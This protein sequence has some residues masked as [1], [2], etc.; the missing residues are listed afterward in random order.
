MSFP[1]VRTFVCESCN[2]C[3]RNL[4]DYGAVLDVNDDEDRWVIRCSVC[5]H[6]IRKA[7]ESDLDDAV[8][9]LLC[10][11]KMLSLELRK[12]RGLGKVAR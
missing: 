11:A 2:K 6:E 1:T 7:S 4:N 5:T 10:E 9:E 8:H 3:N 12:M